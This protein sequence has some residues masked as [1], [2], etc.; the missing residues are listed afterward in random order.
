MT[1]RTPRLTSPA[2]LL[3]ILRIALTPVVIA[4]VLLPFPG[5]GLVAFVVFVIAAATDFL[6]GRL[7]R[8]RGEV[9]PLGVFMDLT[10]DKVLVAGVLI[11]MVEADLLPTW[12]V[13]TILIRELVIAGVRQMAASAQVVIAARALGKAKTLSTLA[14]MAILLLAFDAQTAGPMQ[15]LGIGPA[16]SATGFWLMI[17]A[18]ALTVVSGWDYLRGAL[19]ILMGRP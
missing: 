19:P 15:S 10:A 17:V 11:A 18:T 7:A 9:S 6:D 2:N 13:A 16:L 14:A 8:A 3:G 12:M 1:N 4:L 5:A